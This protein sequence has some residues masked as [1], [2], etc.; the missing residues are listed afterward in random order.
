MIELFDNTADEISRI[1]THR[2]ST[3]F[4]LG[5]KAFAVPVRKHIYAIYAFSR[6][7]DEIVDTFLDRSI[8]ERR[9]LLNT[10]KEATWQAIRLGLSPFPILHAFQHTVRKFSIDR[11]M[12]QAFF[13]SMEMDLENNEHSTTTYDQYIYGS[14]EVIGLMCLKVFVKGD[15]TAYMDM[16][17]PA[18]K[19][20]AAFQKV[21]F[22]RDMT[23][24]FEE[25]GRV[26]FPNIDFIHF[27][28]M[29]KREIEA[30]IAQD[31]EDAYEGILTLPSDVK[32]GVYL[33]YKYYYSLFNKIK[34]T[35]PDML[36]EERLRI[37]DSRKLIIL[38][39]TMLRGYVGAY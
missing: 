23:S 22:L 26:Y 20:G 16:K 4:T 19:L 14:A 11:E 18:R 2:Y 27:D 24:D 29:S 10:Y 30:D 7:T 28:H 31:F 5:I 39:K 8:E 25:R 6:Y 34:K 32:K 1:T 36:Q 9:E 35:Q 17:E 3:S 21:N 13:D 12:I 37:P 33:A 38:I 15:N